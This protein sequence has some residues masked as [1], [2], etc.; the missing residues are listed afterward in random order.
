[1]NELKFCE[2]FKQML[3]VSAFYLEKKSFIPKKIIFS[4]QSLNMPRQIQKMALAVLIF[5]EGFAGNVNKYKI[6]FFW[7]RLKIKI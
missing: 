7:T 6:S 3:K 2:V 4:P 5:S 1:M